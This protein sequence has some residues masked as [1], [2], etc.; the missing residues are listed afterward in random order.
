M[1]VRDIIDEHKQG[2]Y[3]PGKFESGNV[4]FVRIS[5]I[6]D[7]AFL[8]KTTTPMINVESGVLERFS[9]KKNDF[10]FARTG[11]AGRFCL[12]KEDV[13]GIFASYLVRFRFR[14]NYDANFMRYFFLSDSFQCELKSKIHGGV[15][16]NVHA[17]NIKDCLVPEIPL[18]EQKRI[19]KILDKA[20]TAIDTA[21]ANAE[22]NLQN[23][24]E[25]FESTLQSVFKKKGKEWERLQLSALI[26]N[27]WI[28]SHLD[29]NHGGN[30]PRKNEFI[31][32][33]IPYISANCLKNDSIDISLAKYLSPERASTLRKGIAQNN[34]V[35]FAHNATV[36]PV[37]I[38][39]TTEKK[40]ILS[41]S[42]TY[43]RCNP[44]HILPEY[45]A[46]YMRSYEFRSQYI[47]VMRQSTRN[48][49][50]ITK[51]REFYHIIPPINEQKM[52]VDKLDAL[53][54]KS[55]TLEAV[56]QQKIINLEELKTSI[57]QKVFNGELTG[58]HV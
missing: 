53:L 34:D 6:T 54:T 38:L 49:V 12:I 43:Y 8:D 17:E 50:P 30:Y 46:H 42:L 20:F 16:Q 24:R 55:K 56:N 52:I 35:L 58:A 18:T 45:L 32:S 21:K 47:G 10:L 4:H 44:K 22:K 51:Q 57:L 11:G 36:G 7:N 15:N 27:G 31:S 9:I 33:G 41:T 29:G 1:R 48:Q 19:V 37:S 3:K 28:V 23:S 25:L 13:H 39:Y 26:E 5:D 2:Y 40:V 14:K